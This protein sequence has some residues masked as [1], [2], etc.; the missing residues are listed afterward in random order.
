[1]YSASVSGLVCGS[2]AGSVQHVI[3]YAGTKTTGKEWMGVENAGCMTL[4][5]LQI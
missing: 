1:V 4:V 2:A 3:K 5:C